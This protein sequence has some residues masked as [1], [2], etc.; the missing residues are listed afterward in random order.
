M[1]GDLKPG[2][3]TTLGNLRPGDV[4]EWS[5]FGDGAPKFVVVQQTAYPGFGVCVDALYDG[6]GSISEPFLSRPVRYL[7]RGRIEP[8]KIVM[9]SE[10]DP[11]IEQTVRR[12]LAAAVGDGIVT[13][14]RDPTRLT[15]GELVGAA[16]VL[17]DAMGEQQRRVAELEEQVRTLREYA[18]ECAD[19]FDCDNDAHRYDTFCRKCEARAALAATAPKGETPCTT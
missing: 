10:P 3:V 7:G 14:D 2:D 18:R 12:V 15:A 13:Y 16:N 1:A 4:G 19:N 5:G 17:N 11:T 9:D 8:A 6:G